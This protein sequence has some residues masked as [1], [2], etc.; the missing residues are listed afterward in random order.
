[1]RGMQAVAPR[2][3]ANTPSPR[4]RNAQTRRAR[5]VPPG[6]RGDLRRSGRRSRLGLREETT[7][8]MSEHVPIPLRGLWR[9]EAITL[10]SGESD[11]TTH[12]MWLQARSWYVDIRVPAD[13]PRHSGARGFADFTDAEL[14][15]LAEVQGFAGELSAA[16]D[17]CFWRRDHDYQPPGPFPDEGA[18]RI[19]GSVMIEDGVHAA[20]R[21]VW[22]R[23][24]EGQGDSAAFRLDAPAGGLLVIGGDCFMEIEGRAAPLPAGET[25]AAIVQAE[26]DTGRRAVA[27]AHLSLRICYGRI[28]GGRVPW[29]VQLCTLPWL[30]GRSL[31]GP[32]A[33]YDAVAGRLET[34]M[35]GRPLS[36]SLLDASAAPDAVLNLPTPEKAVAL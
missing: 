11:T 25:L 26:L 5:S 30:E 36:W 10:P 22:W 18:Y 9:R 1:M 8:S 23:E 12:V 13:R 3:Q 17:V 20:Y 29:E 27:E 28:N 19:D 33:L 24:P 14:V 4:S 7:P 2:Q 31:L 16:A 32:E 34:R 6:E 35:D 21:E 15:R